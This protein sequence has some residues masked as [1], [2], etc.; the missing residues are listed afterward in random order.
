MSYTE[1]M[2]IQGKNGRVDGR[3]KVMGTAKY[4]AEYALPNLAHGVLVGS[5][6]AKGQI[7]K[8]DIKEAMKAPGVIQVITHKN[9]PKI[10]GLQKG[11]RA[12]KMGLGLRVFHTKK[13]LFNGQPIALVIAE[14]LEQAQHAATLIHVTYEQ[15]AH[16]TD[17]E[18]NMHRA[19]ASPESWLGDQVRGDKTLLKS[20]AVQIDQEYWIETEVHSPME[21]HAT[22]AVWDTAGKLRIFDKNHAVKDVQATL[23]KALKLTE[24]QVEINAEIVGGGFGSGLRVWPHTF[25][26]IMGAQKINRPVKVVVTR[27]QTFA[28][29][30]YRPKS[31]QKLA[32]GADAEGKLIGINHDAMGQTSAYESFSE[33][34]TGISQMLYA[35]PNVGTSYKILPL[36]VST[37]IWMRGP[38][39]VTGAFALE[40]ALDELSYLLKM[41][42][43]ELRIRNYAEKNPSNDLPWS[44]NFLKDCYVRASK[45]FGWE[46]RRSEPGTLKE[47]DWYIGH[48]MA[49]G[50]WSAW[51]IKATVRGV[52]DAKGKLL[53]QSATSDMGPGTAT[54]MVQIAMNAT[55][56]PRDNIKFELGS[57]AL[58][59]SPAQGGS[60]TVAS[61]G[62]A[63]H[64]VCEA[65]KK[66]LFEVVSTPEGSAYKTAKMEDILFE[67]GK[68]A[69]KDRPETQI[70]FESI[71]KQNKDLE[72]DITLS[73]DQSEESKKY[74]ANSFSVHFAEVAVHARTGVTRVRRYVCAADAGK[75]INPSAAASQVSGAVVMGI[76]MA[77]ME[78]LEIDDRYG[79]VVNGDFAGYHIPVQTD[80]PDIDVIF[81]NEP[82]PHLNAMG[83]K[84]LGEIGLI[85]VA[86]AIGN[87][88]YNATGKRLRKLPFSL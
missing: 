16:I 61:V 59:Y 31:W 55:G 46:N 72:I 88:I 70:S 33:G 25:A 62:G 35:C 11:K 4:A 15:E 18:T 48:G 78:T 45:K 81:I 52:L 87:A 64:D 9:S 27:P 43:L 71:F 84:G 85:G 83:A 2:E 24:D 42:P 40:T 7:K 38:G 65:I 41:D 26:A 50:A 53:L 12:K 51:R 8:I 76:G 30:G 5:T 66:K 44:S 82:D 6:I 68:M 36:D 67:N 60:V 39:E 14:R 22:I 75:I 13:I 23:A 37:P 58:P 54:A 34:I 28:M 63:V 49:I 19:I 73:S 69:L 47:G 56:I 80:V 3:A 17:F 86:P 21:M 77:L 79:R 1:Y 57:S 10:Y 20:A 29:V 74:S 32:I